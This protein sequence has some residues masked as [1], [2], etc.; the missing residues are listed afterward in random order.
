MTTFVYISYVQIFG[1]K[2]VPESG[3]G[4]QPGGVGGVGHV[5]HRLHGV[6]NLEEHDGVH[7]DGDAVL[8]QDLLGRHVE[9]DGP[10]VH[11]DDVVDAGEDGEQAGAH[12]AALLDPPQPEDH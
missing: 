8:G 4:Q 11:G 3:G 6:D 5:D 9:G 2:L 1:S 10:E 7:C 12:R